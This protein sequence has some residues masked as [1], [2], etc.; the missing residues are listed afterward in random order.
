MA[1]RR[2]A[3]PRLQPGRP[4]ARAV[5][6]APEAPPA[7]ASPPS[8]SR[9]AASPA[10]SST[11][12][13]AVLL[14]GGAAAV[15]VLPVAAGGVISRGLAGDDAVSASQQGG[16]DLSDVDAASAAD[17]GAGS[18]FA[19]VADDDP[20]LEAMRWADEVGIQPALADGTYAPDG[21][22]GRGALAGVLHRFAGAPE[23]TVGA[24]PTL[25]ADLDE[26]ADRAGALLWLHGRG[27]LWCDQQLRLRPDDG[28]TRDE[29]AATLSA[30]L[31]P[32]LAG[33]GSTWD[34]DGAPEAPGSSPDV[35]WLAA[36]GLVHPSVTTAGSSGDLPLTRAELAA[37]LHRA[38]SVITDCMA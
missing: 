4:G 13:R 7:A 12:R 5:P 14:A 30:L 17:P 34:P 23:V 2:P 31:R 24:A 36:A 11:G 32:A 1:V 28:T 35:R 6:A 9:P 10:P 8:P 20:G 37:A 27:A 19:D 26:D 22:V 33:I 25:V 18:P 29:A 3:P 21:P 16:A 38:N 15:V